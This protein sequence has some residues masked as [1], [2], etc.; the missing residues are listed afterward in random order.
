[1]NLNQIEGLKAA[2]KEE[3]K[4]PLA[5]VPTE[6]ELMSLLTN[7]VMFVEWYKC[8]FGGSYT[9]GRLDQKSTCSHPGHTQ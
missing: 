5:D 6:A 8:P 7:K 1:M 3:M 9:I 2:W 4:K